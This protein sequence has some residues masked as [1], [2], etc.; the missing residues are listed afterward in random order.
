MHA[1]LY[2]ASPVEDYL[3]LIHV[4]REDGAEG[5]SEGEQNLAQLVT[6]ARVPCR[7]RPVHCFACSAPA[8]KRACCALSERWAWTPMHH[9]SSSVLILAA[10]SL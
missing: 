6:R 8:R 9:R 2:V 3:L 5:L 7:A 1:G 4:G 10:P